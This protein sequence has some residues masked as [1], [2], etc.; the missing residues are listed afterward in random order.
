MLLDAAERYQAK[1]KRNRDERAAKRRR[2]MMPA[3]ARDDNE[4][5]ND[6]WYDVPETS[7]VTAQV[8]AIFLRLFNYAHTQCCRTLP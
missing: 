2:L 3:L 1:K 6:N 5:T 8:R 7:Q 4:D